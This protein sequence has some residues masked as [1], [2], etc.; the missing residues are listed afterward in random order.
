MAVV[1]PVW[2]KDDKRSIENHIPVSLVPIASKVLERCTFIDLY[3]HCLATL[4]NPQYGLRRRRLAVLQL[5]V[6]MDHL[7]KSVN[8]G[9]EIEVVY[10]DFERAFDK[11]DYG[12]ILRKLWHIGV[13]GRLWMTIKWYLQNRRQVL[14][15]GNFL[16]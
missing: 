14:R 13:R 6:Y 9:T 11:V 12:V 1:S 16:L 5:L 7:Y 3:E 15:V 10:T 8:Q 2:K 4:V